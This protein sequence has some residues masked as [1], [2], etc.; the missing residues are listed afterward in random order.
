M[1]LPPKSRAHTRSLGV[2]TLGAHAVGRAVRTGSAPLGE[3][4]V[5][6]P[7]RPPAQ[8]IYKDLVGEDQSELLTDAFDIEFKHDFFYEVKSAWCLVGGQ[9][10]D[11]GANSSAD[12]PDDEVD[13][14]EKVINVIDAGQLQETHVATPKAYLKL[15][16]PYMKAR[17]RLCS[18]CGHRIL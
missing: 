11:I 10:I 2:D 5:L 12:G 18:G 14:A 4:L 16:K 9:T 15:F 17:P 6:I 7:A 8:L 13:A 3:Q 1:R